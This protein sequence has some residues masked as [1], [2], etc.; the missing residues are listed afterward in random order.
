MKNYLFVCFAGMKRSPTAVNVAY[1]IAEEKGI[2][3][4]AE[5]KGIFYM[6][7]ENLNLCISELK[8][9][10]RIFVMENGIG[11]ELKENYRVN[12]DKIVNLDIEDIYERDD[13]YLFSLLKSKLECL[14][15]NNK[16]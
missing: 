16:P 14:I 4:N 13:P 12:D 11:L 5:F 6:R 9:Y 10:D 1:S 15:D 3:I 7:G 2:K 8:S